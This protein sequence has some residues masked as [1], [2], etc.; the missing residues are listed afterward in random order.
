MEPFWRIRLSISYWNSR[1][2]IPGRK[3]SG[4]SEYVL[5]C[6]AAE[7]RNWAISHG[8][9]ISRKVRINVVAL[10][11]SLELKIDCRRI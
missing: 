6:F 3:H 1:S 5:A 7:I 11:V 8:V 10:P 2:V 4:T 9:L